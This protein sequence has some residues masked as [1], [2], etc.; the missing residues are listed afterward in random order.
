MKLLNKKVIKELGEV[1]KDFKKEI[2]LKLFTQEFEC[3]FCRDTR[4][5]LEEISAL[6]GK[7]KLEIFDFVADKEEGEKYGIE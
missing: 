6:T 4:Q 7:I 5:L 1:F 3:R 2:S